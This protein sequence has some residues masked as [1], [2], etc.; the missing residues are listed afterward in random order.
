MIE[1]F[2]IGIKLNGSIAKECVKLYLSVLS[3]KRS[4]PSSH[5]V[6]YLSLLSDLLSCVCTQGLLRILKVNSPLFTVLVAREG[7]HWVL[8]TIQNIQEYD[9][10][11]F[12]E[13]EKWRGYLLATRVWVFLFIIPYWD[14]AYLCSTSYIR[15][16]LSS[17]RLS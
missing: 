14:R 8:A 10:T 3:H 13:S 16:I 5:I 6:R 1:W 15:K 9:L 12:N 7:S 17:Y 4:H 2:L 11:Q